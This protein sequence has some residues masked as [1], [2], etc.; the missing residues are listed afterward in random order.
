M[1]VKYCMCMSI[2]AIFLYDD[3]II[4][5][6]L[7]KIKNN[8]NKNH[9]SSYVKYRFFLCHFIIKTVSKTK[10]RLDLNVNISIYI[11][12]RNNITSFLYSFNNINR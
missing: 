3:I 2:F 4:I 8:R 11:T 7:I 12:V 10:V 1:V 6:Y 5:I 9:K